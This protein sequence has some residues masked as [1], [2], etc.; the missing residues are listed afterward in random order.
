MQPSLGDCS[1]TDVT[2]D[3]SPVDRTMEIN[4][5]FIEEAEVKPSQGSTAD[6]SAEDVCSSTDK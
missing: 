3:M 4:G 1:C 6:K 2:V 5:A